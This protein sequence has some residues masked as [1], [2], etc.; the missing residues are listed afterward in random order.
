MRKKTNI[1]LVLENIKLIKEKFDIPVKV[2]VTVSE[3]NLDEIEDIIKLCKN[4][5]VDFIHFNYLI[6]RG[7]G[8]RNVTISNIYR[9]IHKLEFIYDKFH[10][11][12]DEVTVSLP[13]EKIKLDYLTH[14]EPSI[15]EDVMEHIHSSQYVLNLFPE[16]GTFSK[17]WEAKTALPYENF[18]YKEILKENKNLSNRALKFIEC[19]TCKLSSACGLEE[20]CTDDCIILRLKYSIEN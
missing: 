16:K 3:Y 14:N 9:I 17:G 6:A 18:S 19:S 1:S 20:S 8:K 15:K 2:N 4:L 10:D 7:R 11:S 13:V 12:F 5:K